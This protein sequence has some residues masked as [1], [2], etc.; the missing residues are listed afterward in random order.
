[1]REFDALADRVL[2]LDILFHPSLVDH[3]MLRR[4][5]LV[6]GVVEK[7]AGPERDFHCR[8]IVVRDIPDIAF[9]LVARRH[10]LAFD[11]K[12]D[13]V[14]TSSERNDA[15]GSDAHNARKA[16]KTITE[17]LVEADRIGI[18]GIG[19]RGKIHGENEEI[20]GGEG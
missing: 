12:A 11:E 14:S 16:A 19:S 17:L 2:A 4:C 9:V 8:K 15:V 5:A 18:L 7:A 10:R 1:M 3:D 13:R 6:G 20:L